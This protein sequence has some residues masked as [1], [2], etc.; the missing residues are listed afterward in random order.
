MIGLRFGQFFQNLIW[1]PWLEL[2]RTFFTVLL[3]P[4]RYA[5]KTRFQKKKLI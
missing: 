3:K 5:G 4:A 1:S 2:K